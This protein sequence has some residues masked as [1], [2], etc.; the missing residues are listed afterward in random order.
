MFDGKGFADRAYTPL[1]YYETYKPALGL[2][3]A[4]LLAMK[5]DIELFG[6]LL[7]PIEPFA[8]LYNSDLQGVGDL[9]IETA[10]LIAIAL[11]SDLP[12]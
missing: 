4:R 12:T 11:Y 1:G 6:N 5:S 8:I 2:Y 3:T 9:N 7:N 10:S